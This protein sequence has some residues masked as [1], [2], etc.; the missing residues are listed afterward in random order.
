MQV[1]LEHRSWWGYLAECSEKDQKSFM[2]HVINKSCKKGSAES[3]TRIYSTVGI[4]QQLLFGCIDQ[5]LPDVGTWRRGDGLPE[6]TSKWTVSNRQLSAVFTACYFASR[7]VGKAS[8]R[9]T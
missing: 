9:R 1:I 8:Q 4:L 5:N 7:H 2:Q 3:V 6:D